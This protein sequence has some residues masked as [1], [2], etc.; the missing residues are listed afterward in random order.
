MNG[1]RSWA[2]DEYAST[3]IGMPPTGFN[4]IPVKLLLRTKDYGCAREVLKK[5]KPG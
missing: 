1:M 3:L 2:R 4:P 5:F